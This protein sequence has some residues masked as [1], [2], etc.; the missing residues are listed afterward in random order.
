MGW[1]EIDG[2][3]AI[4]EFTLGTLRGADADISGRLERGCAILL[5]FGNM[6]G[7]LGCII[8]FYYCYTGGVIGC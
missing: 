4:D 2:A 1:V 5:M 7:A 3:F 6:E 8:R